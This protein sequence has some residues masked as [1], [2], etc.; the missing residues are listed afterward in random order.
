[1]DPDLKRQLFFWSVFGLF[2][3]YIFMWL[4][5][6]FGLP[7]DVLNQ[8]FSL[9]PGI[10]KY[11]TMNYTKFGKVEDTDSYTNTNAQSSNAQ[12]SNAQSSNKNIKKNKKK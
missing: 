4:I 8:I 11:T 1:M 3:F 2:L 12:S 9:P 5:T 6:I 7:P 10:S